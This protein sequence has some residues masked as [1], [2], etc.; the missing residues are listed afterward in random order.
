MCRHIV[1]GMAVALL[2]SACAPKRNSYTLVKS[3]AGVVLVPPKVARPE[4]ASGR[5]TEAAGGGT[6]CPDG[7]DTLRAVIRGKRVRIDVQREALASRPQGWLWN[8]TAEAER[9]GCLP[10]GTGL[11][12]MARIV[13][14]VPLDPRVAQRLMAADR[15]VSWVEIGPE[16]RLQ[17]VTPILREGAAADAPVV[18][19]TSVTGSG[20]VLNVD[21]KATNALVGFETAWFRL[22]PKNGGPGYGLTPV[23]VERTIEGRT[24]AASTPLATYLR[25]PAESSFYRLYLKADN[26]GTAV[27]QLVITAPTRAELDARTKAVDADPA[28][29]GSADALCVAV[30]RRAAINVWTAVQVNGREVRVR[31]G[32]VRNAIEA[33]GEKDLARVLATL[34][35]ERPYGAGLARVEFDRAGTEILD[36]PLLGGER[37]A[38]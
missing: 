34:M 7:G 38:W 12:V 24:E 6:A 26:D 27:T 4:T 16:S 18:E 5:I 33:A 8:W 19:T 9:G 23:S 3:T 14:S 1:V 13:E 32:S 15:R 36:V 35:V 21:V 2:L 28:R 17:V 37:I 25:F 22:V 30:P 11:R 10:A 20:A 29:C 31:G